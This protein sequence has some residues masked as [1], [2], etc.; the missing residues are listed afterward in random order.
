M[1]KKLIKITL[2]LCFSIVL[3]T[4][5]FAQQQTGSIKGTIVDPEGNFLPGVTVTVASEALMK[6]MSYV[7]TETGS[8]RFPALPPGKYVIK[9]ELQGFKT[10][11]RGDIIVRV[12]M[13]VSVEIPMEMSVLKEEITVTA[14]SPVIDVV[15]SKI[16]VPL[17][18]DLLRNI[19][20]A[21]DL[22]D[23]VN[24]APGAISEGVIHPEENPSVHGSTVRSNTYTFDGVNMNDP[25]VQYPMTTINFD[26]ME[27]V[28]IITAGHP[29]SVPYTDGA[30][31]N[32]VTRSGGNKFTGGA[33]LYYTDK[34][35]AQQLWT[36]EQITSFGISKP[37][38]DKSWI[39]GSLTFG[40][41]VMTDKLWFFSN[42]RY[43][44]QEK[45]TNFIPWT[46]SFG[47]YHGPYDWKH[48]EKMG[49]IKLTSQLTSNIKLMGMFYLVNRYRPM[50]ESPGPYQIF[51]ATTIWDEKDYIVSG[52]LNYILDQNTFFDL[53]V[54]YA[55]RDFP[56]IMQD[57]AQEL[58]YMW[59]Y[60]SAYGGLTPYAN[61]TYLR[62]RFQ[63]GAYFTHFLD[64]FLGGNHE[65][66]GGVEFEDV[67]GDYSWWRKDNLV[68]DLYNGPY[69][70]GR[71]TWNGVPNVGYGRIWFA[72]C[73]PEED[74]TKLVDKVRRMGGYI[75]DSVTFFKRLTLNLGFRFDRT[76]CWKPPG[77]KGAGGNPLSLW[78]GEKYVRPYTADQYPDRYPDGINPFEEIHFEGW[79][80]VMVWNTWSPRIGLVFDLFGDGKTALKASFSRYSE[81]MMIQYVDIF[82][83]FYWN[84]Y[85]FTWYDMNF[86]EQP[87]TQDDYEIW[88]Y[89]FRVMDPEFGK[90]KLDPDASSPLT[91]EFTAGLW[92]ELFKNFST[93]I[94]FI[95]KN[96]HNIY[97]DVLWAP[98]TGEYWYHIDQAAAQK[99]WV[100][101]TAIIPSEDYGDQEVTFY[102]RKNEAPDLFWQSTNVPEL[103]RKY[104]AIEFSLNKRMSDGWQ[105]SGSVVYSK[106]YGNIGGWYW[107]SSG[108]WYH[109][110]DPNYYV[111]TYGRTSV[112]RPL[113][114]K[115]MATFQLPYRFLISAYFRHFS[116]APWA[117]EC[118]IIPPDSWLI[119]NDAQWDWYWVMI[120][121]AGT[122]RT[123]N[124]D[125]LDLRLEKQFRIGNFGKLGVYIDAFNVLGWSN[126]YVG[127]SDVDAYF[128][129]AENDNTGT[130]WTRWDY[131]RIGSVLGLR[132]FKLSIRFNF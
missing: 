48:E 42:F 85:P 71:T 97:E 26:V 115:L 7:S 9:A 82:S 29:A 56:R 13:I 89:D 36:D 94:S 2:F 81:Y 113:Q 98:D 108:R 96:K 83:P 28:E 87:D 57:A 100:P 40:G 112:D 107:D 130:V 73:G 68:W 14:P 122:R 69:L 92:H 12:G 18:S 43:I 58:P 38:V 125:I 120:E 104:W 121:P 61:D 53:R 60:G 63:T 74:S 64:N 99:Y 46:D 32:V 10:I 65:L 127:E 44:K 75:Q 101:F 79:D 20:I 78:I 50:R 72:I 39:D 102:V 114:I 52:T 21:R 95:Y 118:S 27:E 131:K 30:Y 25:V 132:T 15:Q 86:N 111:N 70:Y 24:M 34:K 59:D 35:L 80:N 55:R 103:K 6:T 119:E 16:S 33:T 109:G 37:V 123:R 129:I 17:D 77:T 67:Y 116:G 1:R 8:F 41:P 117:R 47:T 23:I 110:D 22:Y 84:L 31:I 124:T 11:T 5:F 4:A 93:G 76:W 90:L 51:Q 128:P 106:A 3:N 19:P 45:S 88:R 66:K 62:T 49:F 91:D 126:I 105:L 54:N